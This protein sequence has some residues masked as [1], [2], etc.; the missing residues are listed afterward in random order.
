MT[1]H[2]AIKGYLYTVTLNELKLMNH[3][4]LEPDMSYN[5]LLYLDLISLVPQCTASHLAELLGIS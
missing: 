5:T 2:D 4:F 1:L 3:S